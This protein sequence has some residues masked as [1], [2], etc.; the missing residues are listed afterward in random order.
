MVSWQ[1][2]ALPS[3]FHVVQSVSA[4]LAG[5]N[6]VSLHVPMIFLPFAVLVSFTEAWASTAAHQHCHG[7]SEHQQHQA[8]NGEV[9]SFLDKENNWCVPSVP[10]TRTNVFEQRRLR[11][12]S[13]C[14]L[15][16]LTMAV[17][18]HEDRV[19]VA[20]AFVNLHVVH[21]GVGQEHESGGDHRLEPWE[22][23]VSGV[24]LN[25]FVG[26]EMV[27]ERMLRPGEDEGVVDPDWP[28]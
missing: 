15:R 13:Q 23:P 20:G 19:L 28:L 26:D 11:F 9:G 24:L 3:P 10:R 14:V 21:P 17:S 12:P 18:K 8:R 27:E 25:S 7:P 16:I 5:F 22:W 4:P 1:N 6:H 2:L